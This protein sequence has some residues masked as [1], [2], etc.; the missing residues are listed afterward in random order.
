M[1]SNIFDFVISKLCNSSRAVFLRKMLNIGFEN[2]LIVRC[3]FFRIPQI[4]LM[5]V[6][7]FRGPLIYT[8]YIFY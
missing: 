8:I 5:S 7:D 1:V 4:G 6:L 2:A 3:H